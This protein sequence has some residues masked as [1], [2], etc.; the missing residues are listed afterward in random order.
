RGQRL[1][2]CRVVAGLELRIG[3]R[4]DVLH[5]GEESTLGGLR[6][7]RFVHANIDAAVGFLEDVAD[8]LVRGG[9]RGRFGQG[10]ECARRG[11]PLG[12][13][14]I[15]SSPPGGSS[16]SDRATAMPASPLGRESPA[17]RGL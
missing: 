8:A 5:G 14:P 10:R 6:Q 9:P 15:A 7:Q 11:A 12:G 4:R 2:R 16:L 17:R 13:W 3:A 1:Q